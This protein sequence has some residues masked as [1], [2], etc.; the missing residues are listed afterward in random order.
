M[1][2]FIF[3]LYSNIL[4]IF[5][6]IFFIHSNMMEKVK[7]CDL[8]PTTFSAEQD[9]FFMHHIPKIIP[10]SIFKTFF[11]VRDSL[12]WRWRNLKKYGFKTNWVGRNVPSLKSFLRKQER[13]YFNLLPRSNGNLKATALKFQKQP[14]QF[15]TRAL[16]SKDLDF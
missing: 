16:Q 14:F 3:F 2:S 15:I 10:F 11:D 7:G 5:F 4:H 9:Y 1:E 12:I 8:R 6:V 13:I